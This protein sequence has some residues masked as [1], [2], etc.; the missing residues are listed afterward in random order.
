MTTIEINGKQYQAENGQMIIEVADRCGINIPRFCYHKKLSVAANCRMCLVEV[1]NAPKPLPACATPVGEGMKVHTDSPKALAAQKAVMEFLLINHPLDCP[2]CDQGG[3][4]ELQ[5]VAMG[6]GGDVSRFNEGKR[7]VTDEDLGPL[8]ATD[9]TRCIHCTRCVRFG[10][11]VAGIRELG[12]TGRGE[13]MRIGTYVKHAM[14]SEIAANIIDLCPVGALTSKPF[15]FKAR[16]WE[17]RQAAAIAPHDCLGS[18]IYLHTRQQEVMRVV[19]RENE[20]INETWASD[21]DRF[22]YLSLRHEQ[23]LAKPMIKKDGQWQESEWQPA[24]EYTVAGLKQ[25]IKQ[26]GAEHLAA[27]GSPGA[28]VEEL[29]LLQKLMR[30]LGCHNIDHRLQQTDF[31]DQASAPLAPVSQLP[32]AELEKQQAI[33]L[34]G[35]D[36]AREQPLAAVRVRKAALQG[37]QVMAVNML[38]YAFNFAVSEKMIGAPGV[39]ADSLAQIARSCG[40]TDPLLADITASEPADNIAQ[41]LQTVEHAVILLGAGVMNHPQAATLR[42]L[43]QLLAQASGAKVMIM[44]SGANSAGAWLAGAVPHRLPAGEKDQ[45]AGLDVHTVL[46]QPLKAYLLLGCEPEFD[47]AAPKQA[48][49]AM[50]QADFV[51]CLSE[52]Y[53]PA[54]AE[55]ADV[56]LPIAAF[57]ETAGTYVNVD[58]QWQSFKACVN[59]YGEA[60][61][62]WKVLRVLGNLFG[63]PEFDYVS[64]TEVAQ[65]VKARLTAV[66]FAAQDSY[67]P[68]ALPAMPDGFYRIGEWPMYAVDSLVRR[69]QA[70]QTSSVNKAVVAAL[71]AKTAQQYGLSDGDVVQ[72]SQQAGQV[73][74]P[75]VIDECVPAQCVFIPCGVAETMSSGGAFA[76]VEIKKC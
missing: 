4:C 25:V 61:P 56:V 27:L 33:L 26:Y 6:Y 41:K 16:A 54:M 22:S 34:I 76:R 35:S 72:I 49:L 7:V 74:L 71:S 50:Q 14:Q 11:E 32:Y 10:E 75:V 20:A 52:F 67:R 40:V 63:L 1:E 57:A 70:L 48:Q 36:L 17:L 37:A 2:I 21:R 46:Q 23:R 62:A 12:A 30:A 64:C 28:T 38:D 47:C 9:M 31:A 29:F 18:N 60:R 43:V 68:P 45:Q 39:L 69:A 73:S 66:T 42:A 55:Y 13:N 24:L 3:E 59:P 5:D 19:P 51:V 53:T 44:T 15:R 58:G 8:I 65:A